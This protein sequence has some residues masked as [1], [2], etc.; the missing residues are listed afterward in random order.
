MNNSLTLTLSEIKSNKNF[1]MQGKET[2]VK[3]KGYLNYI[4]RNN[5]KDERR[6]ILIL[7]ILN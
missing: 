5:K 2:L 3:I 1:S 7:N 4:L 6:K